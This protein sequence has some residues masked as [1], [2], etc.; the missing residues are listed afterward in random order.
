[1]RFGIY[2]HKI[3]N[4]E[5]KEKYNVNLIVLKENKQIIGWTT[6]HEY[7]RGGKTK[8]SH[9]RSES[10][11]VRTKYVVM[12]LNY[13]FFDKYDIESLTDITVDMVADF[14][15][16]YGMCEL[17]NDNEGTHRKQGT[18]DVAI[19]CIID[20]LT[21][22]LRDKRYKFNFKQDD[23]YRTVQ[24]WSKTKKN[25]IDKKVPVFDVFVKEHYEEK[26]FRDIPT[27]AFTIIMNNIY[28]NHPRI[29]MIAAS[30][31]FAGL[32]PSE[33]CNLRRE[34]S[35]LG[36]GIFMDIIDGKV[37]SVTFDLR[38]EYSLRSD[39]AEVGGI[40][41][42]RKQRVYDSLLDNWL[43]C[44]KRYNA[45]NYG[46]PYETNYGA[47]SNTDYGKAITYKTYFNEFNKAVKEVIP[48]MLADENPEVAY[49]GTL[50]QTNKISPHIL[51]HWFSVHL[52]LN[53]AELNDLMYWR[54]DKSP[55][56]SQ[57]YLN[58]KSDIMRKHNQIA[59]ESFNF[60]MWRNK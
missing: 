15:N 11:D 39:G 4:E 5:T 52:V 37:A 35:K 58:N 55:E 38:N 28:N 21:E 48:V 13:C 6:F 8:L 53:G 46:R 3:I 34:D 57:V 56:S 12:M 44:Y 2:R 43:E 32:R 36:P 41:K 7:I 10:K 23:L 45:Y 17:P 20:F 19:A 27:D 22:L 49:Y 25:F 54:G 60:L 16:D 47:L 14:L 42:H 59:E 50:L 51:R 1:M 18:V 31:A 33:A 24:V 29:L 30:S 40:K 9:Y 26:I